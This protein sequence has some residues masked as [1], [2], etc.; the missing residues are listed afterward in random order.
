MIKNKLFPLRFTLKN[1]E[2]EKF[3]GIKEENRCSDGFLINLLHDVVDLK[4]K[5]FK[6][7]ILHNTDKSRSPKHADRL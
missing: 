1:N 2:K 3:L 6:I 5:D 4:N 7:K